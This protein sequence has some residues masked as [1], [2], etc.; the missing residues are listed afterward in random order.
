MTDTERQLLTLLRERC[1]SEGE[2]VL[3]SG[4]LSTYYFDAKM[5][6][7][8]SEGAALIGEVLYERTKDLGIQAIGGLEVGAIPLTTAAVYTYQRHGQPMEGFFVRNEAKKH[9]T[10]KILEGILQAGSKVAIVDD[11][12]TKGDSIMRAVRA[13]RHAECE[14]V[15]ITV[16]VDRLEGA[17][18]LFAQE[19]VP[20]L[21][22][23]TIEHF[24]TPQATQS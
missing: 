5:L 12:A 8:S 23:F 1:Y 11:V 7:M 21:Q 4:A 16:L 13:V 20:F 24:K 9:G 15:L 6:L 19:G 2:F 3:S 18:E 14:P 17:R 22:I 10:K